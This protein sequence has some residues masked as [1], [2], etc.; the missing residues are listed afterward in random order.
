MI[1]YRAINTLNGKFYIGSSKNWETFEKRKKV[2]LVYGDAYHFQRELRKNPEAFVWETT[3][4]DYNDPVLEQA[5]LDMWF[6]KE[7]C[8][9]LSP[10]ASRPPSFEGELHPLHGR[11]GQE[12]PM[13]GRVWWV[14]S[15]GTKETH[16]FVSPGEGWRQG[17]KKVSIKTREKQSKK[18][19]GR[20]K[21]TEHKRRIAESRTGRLWWVN[22]KGELKSQAQS[23]GPEW[24]RGRKWK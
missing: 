22:E 15:D 10:E 23:P 19:K 20:E 21:T 1:T 11:R 5:L 13:F 24:K 6:G 3:E 7:Q 17:R 18:S 9:N 14:N 12:S 4:D 8:Y 16:A 2:H